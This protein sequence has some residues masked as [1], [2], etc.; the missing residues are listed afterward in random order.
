MEKGIFDT[1]GKMK[2][3]KNTFMVKSFLII[4]SSV[5]IVKM[6]YLVGIMI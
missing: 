6:G 3:S 1:E 4:L 2:H 5:I